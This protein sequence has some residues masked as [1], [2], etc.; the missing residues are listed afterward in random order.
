MSRRVDSTQGHQF[1]ISMKLAH[2][3]NAY[4]K[5][6]YPAIRKRMAR[7]N[8]ALIIKFQNRGAAYNQ[9]VLFGSKPHNR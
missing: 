7:G 8:T 4:V 9:T 2:P 6:W 5:R 1:L 3:T